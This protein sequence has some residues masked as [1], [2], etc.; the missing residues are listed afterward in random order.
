MVMHDLQ[1]YHQHLN[2]INNVEDNVV[3]SDSQS[4]KS[5]NFPVAS[6]KQEMRTFL[7]ERNYK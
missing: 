7:F 1:R 2:L 4:F 6:Y 5:D 3:F